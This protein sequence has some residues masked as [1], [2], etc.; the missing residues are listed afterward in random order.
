MLSV[1]ATGVRYDKRRL[2]S[3]NE[4]VSFEPRAILIISSREP[5]F[6]RCDV[7]ERLLPLYFGR[8]THFVP[9]ESI[10]RELARRRGA[11]MGDLLQRLGSFADKLARTEP[12]AIRFRMADF[13][14]FAH[15]IGEASAGGSEEDVFRL[16][17]TLQL[18]QADFTSDTNDVISILQSLLEKEGQIG[19]IPVG[20]LF[21]Q[22]REIARELKLTL[23]GTVQGFGQLLTNLKPVIEL[24]L[25]AGFKEARGRA[26]MR[27]IKIISKSKPSV[28]DGSGNLSG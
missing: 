3:S 20:M 18:I 12:K 28:D 5:Q 26:R 16:L 24:E 25:N 17:K 14:S 22:C 27:I 6:T 9:E 19:P 1:Y 15:R 13:A 21:L 7:S 8:P 10:F 23:P 11:I 2:Y 4:V